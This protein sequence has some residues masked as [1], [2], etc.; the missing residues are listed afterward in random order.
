VW[1]ANRRIARIA[2]LFFLTRSRRASLGQAR[3]IEPFIGSVSTRAVFSCAAR[4]AVG[5]GR[6]V[7]PAAPGSVVAL[8]RC[9]RCCNPVAPR[10]PTAVSDRGSNSS[11]RLPLVPGFRQLNDG[12]ASGEASRAVRDRQ[13]GSS[14]RDRQLA[15]C[16]AQDRP[17][18]A[19]FGRP[20]RVSTRVSHGGGTLR[21][22]G[23]GG[24]GSWPHPGLTSVDVEA[25]VGHSL[26]RSNRVQ[27][28]R[29][30]RRSPATVAW[31]ANSDDRASRSSRWRPSIRPSFGGT[32]G[33]PPTVRGPVLGDG[34]DC[35][36][37]Q[38]LDG[39]AS[40][41]PTAPLT[42]CSSHAVPSRWRI[43]YCTVRAL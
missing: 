26:A 15:A 12:L 2:I 19:C 27:K 11:Q 9:R 33:A 25:P 43:T 37:W 22:V 24:Y 3:G 42:M 1:P 7:G 21:P 10:A 41:R 40:G 18:A 30:D 31:R 20:T 34:G 6:P 8:R 38:C 4:S 36:R 23:F 5:R 29:D 16:T 32:S 13:P 28:C 14:R 39:M 35:R 17:F